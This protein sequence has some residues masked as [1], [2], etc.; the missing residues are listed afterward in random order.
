[1]LQFWRRGMDR[2]TEY[3]DEKA[4]LLLQGN[5]NTYEAVEQVLENMLVIA[6]KVRIV[7]YSR[8]PRTVCLRV[9]LK[10][11]RYFGNFYNLL[12]H[13]SGVR[14]A[15]LEDS[16]P[17]KSLQVE[18]W[19]EKTFL[20]AAVGILV[21]VV[22]AALAAVILVLVRNRSQRKSLSDISRYT[23]TSMDSSSSIDQEYQSTM[24]SQG[25]F[26]R[27]EHQDMAMDRT[28]S[29]EDT[30]SESSKNYTTP[31]VLRFGIQSSTQQVA[32]SDEDDLSLTMFSIKEETQEDDQSELTNDDLEEDVK[33]VTRGSTPYTGSK[34]EADAGEDSLKSRKL[35]LG[36][37]SFFAPMKS[38]VVKTNKKSRPALGLMVK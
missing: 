35:V 23:N 25:R 28:K 11:C 7:P 12:V 18:S 26:A 34:H 38:A 27:L 36:Q 29:W 3:R 30:Y 2:F 20:G 17:E 22:L 32:E 13:E 33:V 19:N 9:E 24:G 37:L 4:E 15:L 10:G 5:T 16:F 8:H 21:T 31:S 6:S 14:D 1:M